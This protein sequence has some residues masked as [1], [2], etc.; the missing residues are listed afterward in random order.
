[1]EPTQCVIKELKRE[2][3]QNKGTMQGL[4]KAN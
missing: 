2:M 3:Q 4:E 1:M